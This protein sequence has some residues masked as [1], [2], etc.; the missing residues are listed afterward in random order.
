M[1]MISYEDHIEYPFISHFLIE[2]NAPV[3][4][5]R[6]Y[7]TVEP[8]AGFQPMTGHTPSRY[9]KTPVHL[10]TPAQLFRTVG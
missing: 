4:Y 5:P 7:R 10:T 3:I 2:Q 8:W 9:L 6:T 1:L